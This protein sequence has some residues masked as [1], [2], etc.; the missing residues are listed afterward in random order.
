MYGISAGRFAGT[1]MLA[2][3]AAAVA[4]ALLSRTLPAAP[5][6]AAALRPQSQDTYR[7]LGVEL[8]LAMPILSECEPFASEQPHEV[9]MVRTAAGAALAGAEAGRSAPETGGD[10]AAAPCDRDAHPA[11]DA[12]API[13]GLGPGWIIS[14]D[15]VVSLN[16]YVLSDAHSV[17]V[18]PT[19]ALREFTGRVIG[20]TPPRLLPGPA[21]ERPAGPRKHPALIV[22]DT[23]AGSAVDGGWGSVAARDRAAGSVPDVGRTFA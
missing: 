18:R 22:M 2:A 13:D 9:P 14:A 12:G 20:M 16:P 5:G 3:L 11:S 1:S 8:R 19:N 21:A 7:A 6:F 23:P 10:F 4:I 17:M 15:G